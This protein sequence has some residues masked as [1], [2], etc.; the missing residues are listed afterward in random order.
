[1][2]VRKAG[3][4]CDHR[5]HTKLKG[6]FAC[7]PKK[8]AHQK[9]SDAATNTPGKSDAAFPCPPRPRAQLQKRWPEK[10]LCFSV[11]ISSVS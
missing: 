7:M 6:A 4:V 11:K 9:A 2:N 10:F 1:M 3:R 8:K 5:R